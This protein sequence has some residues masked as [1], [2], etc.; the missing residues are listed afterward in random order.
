MISL[1]TVLCLHQQLIVNL[2]LD[3]KMVSGDL[4]GVL[5][6]LQST[7]ARA[8]VTEKRLPR[9]HQ[10]FAACEDEDIKQSFMV[11]TCI[12]VSVPGILTVYSALMCRNSNWLNKHNIMK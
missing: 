7:E 12:F 6:L 11:S 1:L 5:T 8:M 10:S 2:K 9:L 3:N 4:A